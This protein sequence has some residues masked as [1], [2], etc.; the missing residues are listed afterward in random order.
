MQSFHG[1]F[2]SLLIVSGVEYEKDIFPIGYNFYN[3]QSTLLSPS[4]STH[5]E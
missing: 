1:I 5:S 4:F 2:T 3:T